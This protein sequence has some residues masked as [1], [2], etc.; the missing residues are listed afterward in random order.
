MYTAS[1]Q[2]IDTTVS[3]LNDHDK[4]LIDFQAGTYGHFLSGICNLIY[5]DIDTSNA[6]TI[7][8]NSGSAHN[9]SGNQ[10][11]KKFVA[12]HWYSLRLL[13]DVNYKL[14][15]HRVEITL[16]ESDFFIWFVG[17]FK[18]LSDLN[19]DLNNLDKDTFNKF[20]NNHY[21]SIND[22]LKRSFLQ[23]VD[24]F[25]EQSPNCPRHILRDYFRSC[26][27]AKSFHNVFE[28]QKMILTNN[29]AFEI[30]FSNFY[31]GK[32]I[33]KL[34]E[35]FIHLNLEIK[36]MESAKQL[37]AEFLSKQPAYN[38][39]VNCENIL[40]AIRQQ[41]KQQLD[42]NILEEA[43]IALKLEEEYSIACPM[44]D[45]FFTSS[46]VIINFLRENNKL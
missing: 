8:R 36:N 28:I 40:N 37:Y 43:Y 44:H 5:G 34:E 46:S 29:D 12:F 11:N 33:E 18:R 13:A 35:L 19:L 32:L 27:S 10:K 20:N 30:D 24:M 22:D 45:D 25:D 31:N 15:P 14:H 21:R 3:L 42:L 23:D 26:L 38:M 41:E 16:K 17:L 9:L 7:F 4:I 6:T 39:Q 2:E 1:Q